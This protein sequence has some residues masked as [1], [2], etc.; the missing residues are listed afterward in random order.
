MSLKYILYHQY[1]YVYT[2]DRHCSR[3]FNVVISDVMATLDRQNGT[4]TLLGHTV[5]FQ[6]NTVTYNGILVT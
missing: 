1:S 5:M 2:F 4:V 6:L 3:M